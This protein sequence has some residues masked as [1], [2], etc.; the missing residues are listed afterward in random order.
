MSDELVKSN[1]L[2]NS[3]EL[4]DEDIQKAKD[5]SQQLTVKDK[6]SVINYGKDVQDELSNFSQSMLDQVSNNETGDIGNQLTSLMYKM[7][8]NN[9]QSMNHKDNFLMRL[10]HKADES[11]YQLRS[12]YQEVGAQID[13]ISYQLQAKTEEL[14][15]YNQHLNEL[16]NNNLD[17]YKQL[18]ILEKGAEIKRDE[19]KQTL[20]DLPKSSSDFSVQEQIAQTR[21]FYNALD[22]RVYDLKLA[23]EISIQQAPQIRII[24]QT[25]HTLM[26]KVHSS[27]NTAIPLWKDAA[28]IAVAL[29][30]QKQVLMT[31]KWIT[32][33]TN[34]ML[35]QNSKTLKESAISAAKQN[36][37]G[38]ISVDTLRKTENSLNDTIE[39]T[40]QIQQ[41]G[42]AK[43]EQAQKQLDELKSQTKARLESM[44]RKDVTNSSTDNEVK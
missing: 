7:K 30:K 32:D 41:Q 44:A 39:Q 19:V 22:K 36:E 26:E 3:L 38:F 43:R 29:N 12:R 15:N 2:K 40:L 28:F 5:Y 42:Q 37:E 27:I 21:E 8:K 14:S 13:D 11:V 10:F 34:D 35:E 18:R 4:T 9:P 31:Q 33:T 16:Y 20:K 25:N 1:D 17:Y 6:D 23:Q 24:Q